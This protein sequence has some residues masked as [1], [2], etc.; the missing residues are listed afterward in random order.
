MTKL[1]TVSN[2]SNFKCEIEE[3]DWENPELAANCA[4]EHY[5]KVLGHEPKCVEVGTWSVGKENLEI[6][7]IASFAVLGG[8][9]KR[10]TRDELFKYM[11]YPRIVIVNK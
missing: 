5:R 9:V 4:V 6:D 10:I 7:V 8:L 11:D 1:V 2:D 3:G